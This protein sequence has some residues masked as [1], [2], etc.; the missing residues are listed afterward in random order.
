LLRITNR[1]G[2]LFCPKINSVHSNYLTNHSL[3]WLKFS[4][5]FS[6]FFFQHSQQKLA[7]GSAQACNELSRKNDPAF[8]VCRCASEFWITQDAPDRF[9]PPIKVSVVNTVHIIDRIILIWGLS[10]QTR[11][12]LSKFQSD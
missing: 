3:R 4:R 9:R 10:D 8:A 2:K 11:A 5:N 12:G 1:A 7:S 6:R